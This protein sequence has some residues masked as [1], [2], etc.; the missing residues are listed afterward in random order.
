MAA[1]APS[2]T[3]PTSLLAIENSIDQGNP[4]RVMDT[5][6]AMSTDDKEKLLDYAIKHIFLPPKLPNAS[7][8]SPRLEAGLIALV[9]DFA[10]KFVQAEDARSTDWVTVTRMLASMS[11][12]HDGKAMS[13]HTVAEEIEAMHCGG[14]SI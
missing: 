5:F 4:F 6:Q 2:S 7:D 10:D 8:H 1:T 12:V 13:A 9:R 11:R 3:P 14:K